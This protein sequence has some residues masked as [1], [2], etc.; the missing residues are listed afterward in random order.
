M[1][2]QTINSWALNVPKI[3]FVVI[4]LALKFYSP[5]IMKIFLYCIVFKFV[6]FFFHTVDVVRSE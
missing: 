2:N 5:T 1:D 3:N 6:R 4:Y